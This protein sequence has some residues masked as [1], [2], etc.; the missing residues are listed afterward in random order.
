MKDK[1]KIQLEAITSELNALHDT[2]YL[3]SISNEEKAKARIHGELLVPLSGV[4]AQIR[5]L[6]AQISLGVR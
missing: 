3:L 1:L 5:N 6:E 4:L 2:A